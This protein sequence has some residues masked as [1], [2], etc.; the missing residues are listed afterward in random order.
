MVVVP[1]MLKLNSLVFMAPVLFLALA[2]AKA[3][4]AES[5]FSYDL[6][7]NGNAYDLRM[8]MTFDS[9]L[10]PLVRVREYLN[11]AVLM[12][13]VSST[14]TDGY[15]DDYVEPSRVESKFQWNLKL[16]NFA[17]FHSH[18][19]SRCE[20]LT[21]VAETVWNRVCSL[22]TVHG[23]GKNSMVW[24]N[25]NIKCEESGATVSCN[26][27][28]RGVP[29]NL[30]VGRVLIAPAAKIAFEGKRQAIQNFGRI[31]HYID[32]LATSVDYAVDSFDRSAFAERL[33]QAIDGGIRDYKNADWRP[34]K[35][36]HARDSL[37]LN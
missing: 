10:A 1:F 6:T 8:N 16:T 18:L 30:M 37:I 27:I 28:I 29:K 31:F 19:I 3:A 9:N 2:G 21:N 12:N 32:A 5:R 22:D 36:F 4:N 35:P 15:I 34:T 7:L 25:D 24:K 17:V 26:F 14:I 13:Q 33:D 23:D 20:T 11:D